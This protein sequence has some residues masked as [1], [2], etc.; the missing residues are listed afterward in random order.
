MIDIG[1]NVNGVA[2]S[3]D[4]ALVAVAT[5]SGSVNIVEIVS[6][7]I[8]RSFGKVFTASAFCVCFSGDG[9]RLAAGD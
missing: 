6:G 3:F 2:K 9:S 4:D 1:S 7:Q 5:A 8:L